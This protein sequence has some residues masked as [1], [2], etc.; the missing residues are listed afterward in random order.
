M[1]K[2]MGYVGRLN[3][4]YLGRYLFSASVRHDGNS[5]LAKDV[6]W[7]TF[8]AFSAGW[9]ISDERFMEPTQDWLNNLKLRVGYGETGAAGISAYSS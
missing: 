8:P 7:D 5:K 2:S 3:Y 6:R 4:S 1:G 9:R